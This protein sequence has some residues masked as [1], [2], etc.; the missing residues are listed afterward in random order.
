MKILRNF[1]NFVFVLG[2]GL[3]TYGLTSSVIDKVDGSPKVEVVSFPIHLHTDSSPMPIAPLLVV[4]SPAP[5]P[6]LTEAQLVELEQQALI[7]HLAKLYH[8]PEDLVE[9]IIV[10]AYEEGARHDL[11]PLLILAIIMKES[12]LQASVQNRYG[13]MGLMQVVP[14]FHQDKLPRG[15]TPKEV[16][17]KPEGNIQVGTQIL[18][19]YLILKKG[20]MSDA[21]KKYSGNARN[22]EVIVNRYKSELESVLAL[23]LADSS[24]LDLSV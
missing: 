7:T 19:E 18:A 1:S 6:E 17:L 10:S 8:Q 2:L 15:K 4:E 23:A 24:D 12:S 16:L 5:E 14:R 22:Y 11:S 9:R 20:S 3:I 13:A 21:L